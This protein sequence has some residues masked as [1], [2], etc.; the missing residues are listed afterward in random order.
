MLFKGVKIDY[1]PN[2][3]NRLKD[4]Y[5]CNIYQIDLDLNRTF[6]QHKYFNHKSGIIKLKNVLNIWSKY[7]N[8]IGYVQGINFLAGYLLKN[9]KTEEETFWIMNNLIKDDIINYFKK[10]LPGLWLLVYQIYM[11]LDKLDSELNEH[12][13]NND[14]K[15][16]SWITPW[17]LT[18]FT[19]YSNIENIDEILKCIISYGNSFL[20]KFIISTIIIKK[21][22]ILSKKKKDLINYL[23]PNYDYKN[24]IWNDLSIY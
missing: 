4:I 19:K 24:N 13:I 18:L 5:A 21:D 12:L 3:Y 1:V 20:I 6:P 17:I 16:I 9:N 10:D 15:L 14:I 23:N 7:N 22:T 11:S 2:L 8:K